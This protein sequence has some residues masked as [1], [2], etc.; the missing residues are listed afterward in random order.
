MQAGT[1]E[2]FLVPLCNQF[3]RAR[4][5]PNVIHPLG[6]LGHRRTVLAS[7]MTVPSADIASSKSAFR[8]VVVG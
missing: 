6:L 7:L 1:A 5:Q 2:N 3:L 8:S 4:E